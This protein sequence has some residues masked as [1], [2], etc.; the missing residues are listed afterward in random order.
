ML[1]LT[2][3]IGIAAAGCTLGTS[4]PTN[5]VQGGVSSASSLPG[6][7]FSVSLPA[8]W[9]G[10]VMEHCGLDLR[11]PEG[12]AVAISVDTKPIDLATLHDLIAEKYR[13]VKVSEKIVNGERVLLGT[14]AVPEA[15]Y[16]V[17]QAR[18]ATTTETGYYAQGFTSDS[19]QLAEIE[20]LLA[21]IRTI[22]R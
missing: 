5:T 8:G 19:A 2:G 18:S 1:C 15:L 11:G 17:V 12:A 21:T 10:Q 6:A 16:I 14:G 4:V 20:G 9:T 13:D 3:L 7:C 22:S